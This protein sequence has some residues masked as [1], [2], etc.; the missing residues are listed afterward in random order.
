MSDEGT[1]LARV[2]VEAKPHCHEQGEQLT[3]HKVNLHRG[4]SEN[5]VSEENIRERDG[6]K[7]QGCQPGTLP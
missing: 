5:D 6:Y 1:G 7:T 2:E 3:C 4:T